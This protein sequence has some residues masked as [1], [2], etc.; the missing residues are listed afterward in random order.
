[1]SVRTHLVAAVLPLVLVAGLWYLANVAV[2][3]KSAEVVELD[4]VLSRQALRTC[5]VER[6]RQAPLVS[7]VENLLTDGLVV[8]LRTDPPSQQ[9]LMPVSEKRIRISASW[10]SKNGSPERR[11]GASKNLDRTAEVLAGCGG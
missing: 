7:K 11:A 3:S 5:G 2:A 8:S 9:M 4:M 6:L 10:L 1:M